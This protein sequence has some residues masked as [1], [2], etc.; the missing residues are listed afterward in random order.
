VAEAGGL[1]QCWSG[2]IGIVR[3]RRNYVHRVWNCPACQMIS[4]SCLQSS[5]WGAVVDRGRRAGFERRRW[6]RLGFA[7]HPTTSRLPLAMIAIGVDHPLGSSCHLAF[8]L[9]IQLMRRPC[10]R[11]LKLKIETN[12]SVGCWKRQKGAVLP[13]TPPPANICS[14]LPCPEFSALSIE[15]S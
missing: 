7:N 15:R 10:N 3:R 5:V 2:I 12:C 11:G 1:K 13:W 4:V 6:R 9:F 8:S 14:D